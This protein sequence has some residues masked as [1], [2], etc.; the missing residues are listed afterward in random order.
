MTLLILLLLPSA[1]KA[2]DYYLVGSWDGNWNSASAYRFVFTGTTGKVA[3]P[4]SVLS[5]GTS[6][7]SK[8]FSILAIESGTN[9]WRVNPSSTTVVTPGGGAVEC[10]SY[11]SGNNASL[12]LNSPN[13]TGTYTVTMAAVSGDVNTS[14]V[15]LTYSSETG[16]EGGGGTP[17]G[18]YY[19]VGD[20][21][22]WNLSSTTYQFQPVYDQPGVY[23]LYVNSPLNTKGTYATGFVINPAGNTDWNKVIRPT[24]NGSNYVV[25][26]TDVTT[27]AGYVTGGYAQW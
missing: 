18:D 25:N 2:V 24:N 19:L 23:S 11:Y 8:Y 17:A 22:G 12:Q 14:N 15:T 1:A 27:T 16:T 20:F 4:A 3:I 9:Q 5:G 21:N 13:T 10:S 6:T 7:V 26:Q